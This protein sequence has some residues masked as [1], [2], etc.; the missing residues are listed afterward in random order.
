M[1]EQKTVSRSSTEVMEKNIE[2]FHE[3]SGQSKAEIYK[4][5]HTLYIDVMRGQMARKIQQPVES[6]GG[7][8][9]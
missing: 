7:H 5:A 1:A 4:R 9:G 6:L 2:A 8:H 3:E